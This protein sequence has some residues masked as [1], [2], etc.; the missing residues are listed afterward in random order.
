MRRIQLH[1]GGLAVNE[2][3][4]FYVIAWKACSE[5]ALD[6]RK[7]AWNERHRKKTRQIS[8]QIVLSV[9]LSGMSRHCYNTLG[10]PIFKA[11]ACT[12]PK[13]WT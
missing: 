3:E 13:T 1:P 2:E 10:E 9:A 6:T 8:D 11:R 12:T 5:V 7:L 4:S